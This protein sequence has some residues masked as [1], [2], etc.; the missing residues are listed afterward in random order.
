ML[1]LFSPVT[2]YFL[3]NIDLL[4]VIL[5][6]CISIYILL[7]SLLKIKLFFVLCFLTDAGYFQ[8]KMIIVFITS[9][10]F[11]YKVIATYFNDSISSPPPPH[12][13]LCVC[14]HVCV[15]MVKNLS[16]YKEE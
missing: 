11:F 15:F 7:V 14:V 3:R 2:H 1:K 8:L 10:V 4:G 9:L 13:Y 12:L 16:N 6:F 5:L